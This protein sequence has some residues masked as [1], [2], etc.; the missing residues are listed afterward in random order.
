[1]GLD[2][3]RD[4]LVRGREKRVAEVTE[5]KAAGERLKVAE[6][7][8]T[9]KNYAAAYY[10]FY[11]YIK[12]KV[13]IEIRKKLGGAQVSD[14]EAVEMAAEKGMMGLDK[15]IAMDLLAGASSAMTARGIGLKECMKIRSIARRLV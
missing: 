1:M 2:K 13:G 4:E 7:F 6:G 9:A 14:A 11:V 3:V 8:F 12:S 15:K 5:Y 10:M